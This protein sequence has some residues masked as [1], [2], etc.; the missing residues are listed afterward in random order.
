MKDSVQ[1][2]PTTTWENLA[3]ERQVHTIRLGPQIRFLLLVLSCCA[4]SGSAR[5][6]LDPAKA[7]SQYTHQ[8]WDTASGLPHNSV[9]SIAQTPDGYLWLGTEEGLVRFDGVRF[10]IFDAR[11]TP[12]LHNSEIFA[13]LLDH[14]NRLWIGTHGGGLSCL[15]NGQF[16][17]Y[18][19][20]NGLPNDS[21]R[22][23]YEDRNGALWIAMDAAGLARFED[24]RFRVFT[25]ADGLPDNTVTAI[26]EDDRGN[27]WVGTHSGLSRFSNGRFVRAP[28]MPDL[29]DCYVHSIVAGRQGTIWVGTN[30]QGLFRLSR[31]G[32]KRFTS[33]DGLT[34]NSI[35]SLY[36]DSAGTLWAGAMAGG[37]SRVIDGRVVSFTE[38]DGPS[39]DIY[40]VFEDREENLWVAMAHGG[41]HCFRNS[42][43]ITLSK[44]DGLR[45]DAI[46]GVNGDDETGALWFGSEYGLTRWNKGQLS[47]Y[48]TKQRLPDNTVFSV[49]TDGRGDVWV[50]TRRGVGRLSHGKFVT[51]TV[52]DGL[53]SDIVTSTYVD[54]KGDLWVGTREGLSHFD[55]QRFISYTT[56]NGLSNSNVV[57]IY[58]DARGTFWIGTDGGGLNKFENGHFSCYTTRDGLSSDIV[59]AIYGEPDGTLWLGTNGGGLDRFR[60]GKFTSYTSR[61]GMFDDSIFEILDDHRGHLWMSS[62][63]GVFEISKSDLNAFAEGKIATITPIAYGTSDG[64]K[65]RECNGGF[66]SA[67]CRMKDGRLCFP[68]MKGLAIVDPAHLVKPRIPPPAVIE[69]VIVDNKEIP[70]GTTLTLPPGKGQ[71]EFQFT[72]PSFAAPENVRFRY[73]LEGFDKD[74]TQ[75]GTRR[76]A[77]YTNIPH[78]RYRFRVRVGNGTTWNSQ[79]TSVSFTLEPHYYETKAFYFLVTLLVISLCGWIYGLRVN[80]LKTREDR[81]IQLVNEHTA[82]LQLSERELRRSRD[83]LE[84]RVQERTRELLKLNQALEA[85]IAVR[86]R[87]EEQLIDAKDTAE[88]AHRAKSEF[89]ANMSHEIRTPINGILGMTEITLSTELTPEQREYLDIVK[90]SGDSLLAIVNQI[91]DFSKL[92]ARKLTLEKVPIQVRTCVDELIRSVSLRTRQKGLELHAEVDRDVPERL[93][94]DPLRL[95]QVLLNLVDNAIKFTA[96]GGVY[97]RVALEDL[98]TREAFLHFSVTDT[99]IGISPAKQHTIFEAFTQADTS[100]TR[101]FGGTGLGLTISSQ[102]VA[103]M[104][105]RMWVESEMEKGSTFHFTA[106]FEFC[107]PGMPKSDRE[108]AINAPASAVA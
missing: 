43:F 32:V 108:A 5:A 89:L 20:R 73:M 30:G 12:G 16:T 38:K 27:I 42:S 45:S 51:F 49:A 7:I 74:W 75:A 86:R 62:N 1:Q 53:P 55:G 66:E 61:R 3:R 4:L 64:M 54:R 100:S 40:A 60:D 68:T 92:E 98:S 104:G 107:T 17:S 10:T 71:L 72:A 9:L 77:Y 31:S 23:L 2:S 11:N 97:L 13:L 56:Q 50:G 67:G 59:W 21:V 22:A 65:S 47:F 24:G 84:L 26:S 76:V 99:G 58:Q 15:Y 34:S 70:W 14:K 105:G 57:S 63:R 35:L 94:G 101:R 80:Q 19:R 39:G 52:K 93:L 46:L 36:L 25:K 95:R 78:G 88:A 18:T 6:A 82:A 103:M 87:T 48:T 69:H 37:L 28:L 41:L 91:L 29:G 44:Q 85:E 33:A 90:I 79:E 106:R 83:E 96:R 81:L 102:I 8:F